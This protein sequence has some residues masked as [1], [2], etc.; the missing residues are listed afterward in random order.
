MFSGK[1]NILGGGETTSNLTLRE[2]HER[3]FTANSNGAQNSVQNASPFTTSSTA[4]SEIN[5]QR[6]NILD[7]DI[8]SLTGGEFFDSVNIISIQESPIEDTSNLSAVLAEAIRDSKP[9]HNS[10]LSLEGQGRVIE[11]E[12]L[13]RNTTPN[14]LAQL[15]TVHLRNFQESVLS[16]MD[17]MSNLTQAVANN[18]SYHNAILHTPSNH[19]SGIKTVLKLFSK[20][21]LEFLEKLILGSTLENQIIVVCF[22]VKF[23]GIFISA[24]GLSYFVGG[25]N[26]RGI[27][28]DIRISLRN[29]LTES[30]VVLSEAAQELVNIRNNAR[31]I[32][33]NS[34][35]EFISANNSIHD[36]AS[37]ANSARTW[38]GWAMHYA[39]RGAL[40]IGGVLSV[41]FGLGFAVYLGPSF[42]LSIGR[43]TGLTF[44][45]GAAAAAAL[46]RRIPVPVQERATAA[47]TAAAIAFATTCARLSGHIDAIAKMQFEN[48]F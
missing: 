21:V 32:N 4:G 23:A 26:I 18:S 8:D 17:N 13:I 39:G 16:H 20:E 9:A 45:T 34:S 5:G 47:V 6:H 7:S 29:I 38:T 35:N 22:L 33:Q 24:C 2:I 15:G 3:F 12:N 41:G 43:I 14:H 25:N 28:T 37:A 19:F 27:L 42:V 1:S 44:Q 31:L 36:T 48:Y 10:A 46:L 30:R 40:I 11:L